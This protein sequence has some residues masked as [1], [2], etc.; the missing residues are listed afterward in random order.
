MKQNSVDKLDTN[1]STQR[2]FV[3]PMKV[4]KVSLSGSNLTKQ[5][6][7]AGSTAYQALS[8][9]E[10]ATG[11]AAKLA[12]KRSSLTDMFR[13]L[14][15]NKDGTVTPSEMAAGL[16]GLG[17]EPSK[18]E[19][20]LVV[21]LTDTNGDGTITYA[22]FSRSFNLDGVNQIPTGRSTGTNYHGA[23][24]GGMPAVLGHAA[25]SPSGLRT[26]G[27]RVA[28]GT[29]RD[30]TPRPRF[31]MVVSTR[32]AKEASRRE[33]RKKQLSDSGGS[34]TGTDA[35]QISYRGRKV[36]LL[37]DLGKLHPKPVFS[38]AELRERREKED[39]SNRVKHESKHR[40]KMKDQGLIDPRDWDAKRTYQFNI[41]GDARFPDGP[42][43]FDLTLLRRGVARAEAAAEKADKAVAAGKGAGG[44]GFKTTVKEILRGE[45]KSSRVDEVKSSNR[46][47]RSEATRSETFRSF[48]TPR[49]EDLQRLKQR[50]GLAGLPR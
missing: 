48:R 47:A 1:R 23:S 18:R 3:S 24:L 30:S 9:K 21:T 11:L 36:T 22:E 46:T 31:A 6:R 39:K 29:G 45:G 19:M 15:R 7:E 2:A 28:L 42:A 34:E 43:G 35:P 4:P 25:S 49:L 10:L 27:Q 5:M 38:P 13:E 32:A 41:A 26:A 12:S 17:I 44:V 37:D 33:R 20:D 14:D 50:E 8:Q 40:Q 16:K